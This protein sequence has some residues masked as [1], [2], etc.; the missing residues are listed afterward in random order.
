MVFNFETSP[1]NISCCCLAFKN[2]RNT[3]RFA[4]SRLNT[5]GA[6]YLTGFNIKIHHAYILCCI[7][8]LKYFSGTF[9][10][11]FY[12]VSTF[13]VSYLLFLTLKRNQRRVFVGLKPLKHKL[14]FPASFITCK[15]RAVALLF[16][17]SPLITSVKLIFLLFNLK[18]YQ[19]TSLAYNL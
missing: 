4:L 11:T 10:F 18:R 12:F 14:W 13:F 6:L 5:S 19:W 9:L 17:F 15:Y 8:T 16:L 3:L 7:L 1:I 2:I